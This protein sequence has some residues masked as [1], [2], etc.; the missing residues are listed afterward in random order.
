MFWEQTQNY[1]TAPVGLCMLDRDLRYVRINEL[2]ARAH[3]VSVEDHIGRTL[4][5]VSPYVADAL[6]LL[7][8]KV[9][10]TGEPLP[11]FELCTDP[12][13]PERRRWWMSN[14]RALKS[15]S[16]DVVGVS[17]VVQEITKLKSAE[18]A[19]RASEAALRESHA[20]LRELAGRLLQ[21]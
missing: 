16:G 13:E 5:E 14:Y 7:L 12:P 9:I 11:H 20:D 2:L 4:R 10:E 19:L 15:E 17:G 21:A 18:G 3:G 6:E 8:R 1:Q